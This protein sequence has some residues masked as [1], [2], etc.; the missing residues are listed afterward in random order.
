MDDVLVNFDNERRLAAAGVISEFAARRQVVFFTC[1][2]ET[3]ETF[4]KAAGEVTMVE[5][6]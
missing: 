5:M 6:G 3:A 4:V 2:P 1:H